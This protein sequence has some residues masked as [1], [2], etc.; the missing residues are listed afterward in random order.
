MMMT[1]PYV[2]HLRD[3]WYALCRHLNLAGD[4]DRAFG[5]LAV[6]YDGQG[7]H[8]HNLE[9]LVE[10]LDLLDGVRHLAGDD[11]VVEAAIWFHDAIYDATR[12]DNEE[13]SADLAAET[14][15]ALGLD[16]VR[17]QSIR[18][19]IDATRHTQPPADSDDCLITDIDLCILGQSEERFDAY[20]RAIR[21]E[22]A[23]V[24]EDAFR[25][26]RCAVL[27]R[28]LDRPSIY[29]TEHF[30]TAFERAARENLARSIARLEIGGAR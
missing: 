28:F 18:R 19:L 29:S 9:H 17:T 27:R 30:R 15:G 25:A 6:L 2:Q 12:S 22:Y 3:Q 1:R 21:R 5:M 24:S 4:I 7:R 20:E 8:Y 26:G 11:S 10:C 16:P 13:R 23:H 14:L